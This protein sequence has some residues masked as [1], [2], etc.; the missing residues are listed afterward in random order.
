[1]QTL[2]LTEPLVRMMPLLYGYPLGVQRLQSDHVK[3]HIGATMVQLSNRILGHC[4]EG[5]VFESSQFAQ[6]V[7]L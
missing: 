5:Q 7:Q 4:E 6:F 1:M 2:T 3:Y